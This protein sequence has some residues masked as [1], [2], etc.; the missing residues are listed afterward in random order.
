VFSIG[1]SFVQMTKCR[2]KHSGATL[3]LLARRDTQHG[4]LRGQGSRL[5]GLCPVGIGGCGGSPGSGCPDFVPITLIPI[6]FYS[7]KARASANT[8][9]GV[10][11]QASSGA[12]QLFQT[13]PDVRRLRVRQRVLLA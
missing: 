10:R 8:F 7:P 12:Q 9:T 3:L 13:S 1:S 2:L 5:A 4:G 6:K 11:I